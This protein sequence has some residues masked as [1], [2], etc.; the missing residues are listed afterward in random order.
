MAYLLAVE[1]SQDGSEIT[2]HGSAEG[3][4]ALARW[5]VALAHVAEQGERD[6]A[7]LLSEAWGAGELA[8][9]APMPGTSGE[10]PVHQLT[11]YAWP[12]GAQADSGAAGPQASSE[13][14]AS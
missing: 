13:P 11:I 6:H 2:L 3:L 7:H 8:G 14:P 10:R 4:R 1:S 9:R 12:D 5:L